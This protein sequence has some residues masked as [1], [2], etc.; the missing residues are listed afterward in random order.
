MVLVVHPRSLTVPIPRTLRAALVL[1]T[2]GAAGLAAAQ[3]P[4]AAPA[5]P[6][7]AARPIL[8][9]PISGVDG[10]ELVILAITLEPGASSPPHTHPGDCYGTLVDGEI[11]F[12]LAGQP[13]RR[14][15]AGEA[16]ANA[17]PNVPHQ[18]TNVGST[19]VRMFNTLVVE[20][21]KP[22]TVPVAEPVR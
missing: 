15:K 7:F 13:A 1:A 12:R 22:R 10:K 4:G 2:L 6:G 17:N 8:V 18:F 20:K 16:Y 9:S 5:T 3:T 21:G 14:V 19:P 11:E